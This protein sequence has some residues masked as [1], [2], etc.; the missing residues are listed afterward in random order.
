VAGIGDN[1]ITL[2]YLHFAGLRII[3]DEGT[4]GIHHSACAFI[5]IGSLPP[6]HPQANVSPPSGSGGEPIRTTGEKAWHSV[7]SVEGARRAA[8]GGG[9]GWSLW[10]GSEEGGR[11]GGK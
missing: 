2:K 4:L 5:Q 11:G 8:I 7:Y 6:P 9:E 1:V 10:R 3:K